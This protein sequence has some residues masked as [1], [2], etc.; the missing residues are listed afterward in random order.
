MAFDTLCKSSDSLL[1]KQDLR[2]IIN[3]MEQALRNGMHMNFLYVFFLF[4]IS[5]TYYY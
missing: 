5:I 1:Q 2:K 4:S 3:G